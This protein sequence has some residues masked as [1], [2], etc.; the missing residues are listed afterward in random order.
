VTIKTGSA[1][2]EMKKDGTITIKGKDITVEGSGKI[3]VKAS[4][5]VV[6]KGSKI[7]QN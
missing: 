2:N 3:S 6:I 5:D 7:L 1:S 4:K